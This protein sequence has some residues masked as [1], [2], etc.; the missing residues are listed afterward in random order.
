MA[1]RVIQGTVVSDK[2]DKTI[3]VS[4]QRRKKHRFYHKVISVTKQ[5]KAHDEAND[6]H[7][8]DVVSIIETA[9]LSKDKHW[10]VIEVLSRGDVAEIAPDSIGLDIEAV[11]G[12]AAP[13]DE[14]GDETAGE[15][16]GSGSPAIDDSEGGE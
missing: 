7:L 14:P 6:C 11:A 8:G 3:V 4:V 13:D 10:R 15:E 12:A 5:Y 16:T 9:P 1:T 2:M